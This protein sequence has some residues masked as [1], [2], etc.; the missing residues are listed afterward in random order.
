REAERTNNGAARKLFQ[1]LAVPHDL[2][3]LLSGTR[4]RVQPIPDY[5]PPG[6]KP[7]FARRSVKAIPGERGAK[8]FTLT[9][10]D[11][12]SLEPYENRAL[13]QVDE[14]LSKTIPDRGQPAN[15]QQAQER[16]ERLREAE[17]ALAAVI[18][19]H[20]SARATEQRDENPGWKKLETRLRSK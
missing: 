14:F 2:V 9:G 5:V 12:K 20:D 8:E 4:V 11:T 13:E 15:P 18:T 16:L 3:T 6:E 10:P 7:R 17:K 19:F 1:S